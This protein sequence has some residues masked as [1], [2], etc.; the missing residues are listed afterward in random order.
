VGRTLGVLS[1]VEGGN[2]GGKYRGGEGEEGGGDER[3]EGETR[4]LIF[5]LR[6]GGHCEAF[7]FSF[8]G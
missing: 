2:E 8:P 4:P 1:K 3:A 7:L 5:K 6:G